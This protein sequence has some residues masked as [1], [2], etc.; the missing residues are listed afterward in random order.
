M[1]IK[2]TSVCHTC[3]APL[4]PRFMARGYVNKSFIRAY[5]RI[6]PIFLDNNAM[7]YSFVGLKVHRVCYGCFKNKVRP[8]PKS[9]RCRELGRIRYL[10]PRSKAKT[11]AELVQ[12]FEGLLRRA[13]VN[14]LNTTYTPVT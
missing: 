8:D 4:E 13:H 7:Y 10:A 11:E 6:R 2:W 14:N 1:Y 12:W 9:L 5:K 3:E